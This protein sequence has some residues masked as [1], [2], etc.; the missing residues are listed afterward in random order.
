MHISIPPS[1]QGH[2]RPNTMWGGLSRKNNSKEL[3]PWWWGGGW[4]LS[5]KTTVVQGLAPS[6]LKEA[7]WKEREDFH[8]GWVEGKGGAPL[9]GK[10][11]KQIQYKFAQ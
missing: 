6:S 8:T 4:K 11:N 2:V 5:L 3:S 7:P 1:K 10:Q 9:G